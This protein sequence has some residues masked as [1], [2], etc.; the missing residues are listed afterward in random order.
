MTS[1]REREREREIELG[2][3]HPSLVAPEGHIVKRE[4]TTPSASPR[5]Y[6]TQ[7]QVA[8]GEKARATDLILR[9]CVFR[10]TPTHNKRP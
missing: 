9:R 10:R 1:E 8:K 6:I 7:G 5:A 4:H 3:N 2:E